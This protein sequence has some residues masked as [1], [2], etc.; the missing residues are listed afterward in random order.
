MTQVEYVDILFIDC[1]FTPSQKRDFLG[2]RF[3]GRRYADELTPAE[4]HKLIGDLKERKVVPVPEVE[5]IDSDVDL[6]ARDRFKRRNK[7]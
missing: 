7:Q 3:N 1:G 6:T 5:E 2:L 4:L